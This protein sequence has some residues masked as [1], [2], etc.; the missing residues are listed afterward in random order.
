MGKIMLRRPNVD[1]Q[2]FKLY[3]EGCVYYNMTSSL[4]INQLMGSIMQTGPRK[5]VVS[6]CDF[7]CEK[8]RRVC[9][10]VKRKGV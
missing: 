10:C 3:M 7:M 9:V 2:A 6:S 5:F 8:K 4:R 1:M